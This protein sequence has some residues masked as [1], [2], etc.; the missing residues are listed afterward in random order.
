M[1]IG[2]KNE[3]TRAPTCQ[4]FA[5]YL[6]YNDTIDFQTTNGSCPH[7]HRFLIKAIIITGQF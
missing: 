2:N 5:K 3:T 6:D 7:S 4:N 1:Q